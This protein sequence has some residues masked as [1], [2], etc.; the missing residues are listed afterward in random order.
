MVKF[1]TVLGPWPYA[2]NLYHYVCDS[3]MYALWL[4]SGPVA[5][6]GPTYIMIYVT[7]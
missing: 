5:G 7:V 1:S 4:S 2:T 3:M 6:L